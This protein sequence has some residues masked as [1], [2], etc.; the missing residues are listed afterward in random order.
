MLR[1]ILL[2]ILLNA[3]LILGFMTLQNWELDQEQRQSELRHRFINKAMQTYPLKDIKLEKG[4]VLLNPEKVEEL[5]N[6]YESFGPK[7]QLPVLW[8]N[9]YDNVVNKEEFASTRVRP[10]FEKLSERL[11]Q[12]LLL[13]ES[14]GWPT[15]TKTTRSM[16]AILNSEMKDR[17][18]VARLNQGLND[19]IDTVLNSRLSTRN[20]EQ[21]L[22]K[23]SGVEQA[24]LDVENLQDEVKLEKVWLNTLSGLTAERLLSLQIK[25]D[26]S[27]KHGFLSLY[28]ALYVAFFMMNFMLLWDWGRNK[29]QK[30][31]FLKDKKIFTVEGL[32]CSRTAMEKSLVKCQRM[33]KG[34]EPSFNI[35]EWESHDVLF[36]AQM[37]E[38]L[39]EVM[40]ELALEEKIQ[41]RLSLAKQGEDRVTCQIDC[42]CLNQSDALPLTFFEVMNDKIEQLSSKLRPY[43]GQLNWKCLYNESGAYELCLTVGFPRSP[44]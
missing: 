25:G 20:K 23:A 31:K 14:K 42:S 40:K 41:T 22:A 35:R 38:S 8:K 21:A 2:F 6:W 33:L 34:R 30:T 9:H 32:L 7:L 43:R 24:L 26:V 28:S 18:D 10:Y 13:V 27:E 39:A 37:Q 36:T 29:S 4:P 17:F 44:L 3:S 11:Q 5:N 15:L 1:K 12:M 16:L 19:Y